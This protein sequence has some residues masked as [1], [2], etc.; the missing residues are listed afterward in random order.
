MGTQWGII[1]LHR[2]IGVN[3]KKSSSQ[4][5]T[6]RKAETYVEVAAGSVD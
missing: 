2:N 6:A 4:K 1:F 3:L 5:L